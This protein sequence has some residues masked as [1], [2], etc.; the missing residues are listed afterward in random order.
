ML[1]IGGILA[2]VFAA[3]GLQ[4]C[5]QDTSDVVSGT[6]RVQRTPAA[7]YY[8]VEY[9][10]RRVADPAKVQRRRAKDPVIDSA[11]ADVSAF[12]ASGDRVKSKDPGRDTLSLE[13]GATLV[14]PSTT[15]L[16]SKHFADEVAYYYSIADTPRVDTMRIGFWISTSGAVKGVYIRENENEKIPASIYDQVIGASLKLRKWGTP[17]GYWKRKRFLRKQEFVRDN[18]Y[19]DMYVIIAS[20]PMSVEQKKSKV[21]YAGKDVCLNP[22]KLPQNRKQ[23]ERVLAESKPKEK[24]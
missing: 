14:H 20:F 2:I 13:K 23:A 10:M 12:A 24:R 9:Y 4:L 5:A 22:P 17:G 21:R 1:R 19:C 15:T 7:P 11:S 18:Y 3:A 16:F 6:I 8:K